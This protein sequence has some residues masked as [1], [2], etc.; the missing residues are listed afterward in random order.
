MRRVRPTVLLFVILLGACTVERVPEGPSGRPEARAPEQTPL[1]TVAGGVSAEP[2]DQSEPAIEPPPTELPP[3]PTPTPEPIETV[4]PAAVARGLTLWHPFAEN[5]PEEAIVAAQVARFREQHAELPLNVLRVDGATLAYRFEAEAAAGGGPD[6]VI[7]ANEVL[8]REA[9]AGLLLS[10]DDVP[11]VVSASGLE[12]VDGKSYG[13]R[14]T[15]TT[16]ALFFNR[17]RVPEPPATTQALLD[18]ARAGTKVVLLRSAFH[19]FGFFGAFGGRLFDDTGRCIADTG[20]FADAFAYLDELKSAGVVF[21]TGGAE[22]AEQ[23]RSGQADIVVDGSWMLADY[24]A[25]LGDRLGVAAL[26]SGPAGP[27]TP[28]IGGSSI[29]VNAASERTAEAIALAVVLAAPEAQQQLAEQTRALPAD[30]NIALADPVLG[31]LAAAALAGVPRPQ[32]TELDAFWI[33]FDRALAEV[34][35]GD[36]APPDAVSRACATMNTDNER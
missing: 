27:A 13:I 20:G 3:T 5:S 1:A 10:P 24:T 25:A 34:L 18:A 26:P 28:L 11:A 12:P 22:A 19:N 31:G 32:R 29:V 30:P 9:R 16:V 6:I 17:E 7:V 21:A 14:L 23:F 33:P 36:I 35:D 15:R 4:E 8:G 2:S